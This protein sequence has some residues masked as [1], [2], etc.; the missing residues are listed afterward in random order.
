M[1]EPFA[2]IGKLYNRAFAMSFEHGMDYCEKQ[3]EKLEKKLGANKDKMSQDKIHEFQQ[4]IAILR[5]FAEPKEL[6]SD[7]DKQIFIHAALHVGLL[8]ATLLLFIIPA[9][10]SGE[11]DEEEVIV[12]AKV[13]E[14]ADDEPTKKT[15]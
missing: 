5:S 6:T 1:G 9:E 7:D 15:K 3:V 13:V 11:K 2:S 12:E 10:D 8:F 4:K 14:G